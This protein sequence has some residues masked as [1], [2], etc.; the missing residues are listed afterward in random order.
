M[1]LSFYRMREN[2]II[3]RM[4]TQGSACFDLHVAFDPSSEYLINYD[5]GVK[6]PIMTDLDDRRYI[7]IR[8]SQRFLIPTG[9]KAWIPDG[10][11]VRV[12]PRSGMAVK[13]GLTLSNA[14]GV[15]D[16]DY[17]DEWFITAYNIGTKDVA[18]FDGDRIAQ[19]EL[20]KTETYIINELEH[21]P[22]RTTRQGGFG[23][24]GN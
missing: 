22:Q 2:A 14:E 11:S 8:P 3:P 12:H 19:G 24:T 16:S 4:A 6:I 17:V 18:V 10:Y 20:V 7:S 9:L 15:I 23:S 13:H 21:E 5:S 1:F